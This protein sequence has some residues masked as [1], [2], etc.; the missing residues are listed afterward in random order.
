[1]LLYFDVEKLIVFVKSL[2][3]NYGTRLMDDP[4]VFH[5]KDFIKFKISIKSR[6]RYLGSTGHHKKNVYESDFWIREYG[7]TTGKVIFTYEHPTCLH[8]LEYQKLTSS[9]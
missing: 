7:Y 5:T 9:I 2:N 3:F 4:I 6:H 1:M 8:K